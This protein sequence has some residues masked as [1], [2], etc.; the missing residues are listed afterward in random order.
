LE[1]G[2]NTLERLGCELVVSAVRAGHDIRVRVGGSSMVPTLWP[3]DELLVRAIGTVE[4]SQG[5]ILLFVR[6]GR[7]CTHRLV[8]KFDD[9]G[10]RSLITRGDTA[11]KRDPPRSPEQILGSVMSVF[12]NGHQVPIASS[13]PGKLLSFGIR[14]SG[15][16]RRVVLKI[17]VFRRR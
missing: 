13:L 9:C 5:D 10:T 3:G 7:L 15:F 11:L 8:S 12:R 2:T 14:H 16:I 17:Y 6:D 1:A 4:P